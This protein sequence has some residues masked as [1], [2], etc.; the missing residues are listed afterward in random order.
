MDRW[1]TVK[2]HP[3]FVALAVLVFSAADYASSTVQ[4]IA[5]FKN[6]PSSLLLALPYLVALAL[7]IAIPQ[8][9]EK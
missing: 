9:K 1:T 8:K 7:I 5:A 2:K 4:N 6:L 3:V